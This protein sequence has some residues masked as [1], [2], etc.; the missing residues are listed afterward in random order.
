MSGKV[1]QPLVLIEISYGWYQ[2]AFFLVSWAFLCVCAFILCKL[3]LLYC[4]HHL[5]GM[6]R[7]E[8]IYLSLSRLE[9]AVFSLFRRCS[10]WAEFDAERCTTRSCQR[11]MMKRHHLTETWLRS[12]LLLHPHSLNAIKNLFHQGLWSPVFSTSRAHLVQASQHP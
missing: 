8:S 2:F 10:C 4:W 9:G 7:G 5:E 11:Q 12:T 1:A 6:I 3:S